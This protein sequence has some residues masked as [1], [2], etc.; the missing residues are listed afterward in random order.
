[1]ASDGT[2]QYDHMS[3][4]CK[5]HTFYTVT[6]SKW[7]FFWEIQ[8]TQNENGLLKKEINVRPAFPDIKACYRTVRI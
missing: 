1:M 5:P 6:Y 8:K 7:D 2:N 3:M 4:L